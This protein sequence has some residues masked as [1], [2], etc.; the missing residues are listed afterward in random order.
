MDRSTYPDRV[1]V[2]ATDLQRDASAREEHIT[3]RHRD[4]TTPGIVTGCVVSNGSTAG[5][6][7]VTA[8]RAYTSG[9][10]WLDVPA[11][12]TGG[13]AAADSTVANPASQAPNNLVCAVYTEV[14]GNPGAHET[15]GTVKNREAT[16]S[17]RLAVFT[18]AQYDALPATDTDL[19]KDAVDR[20]VVLARCWADGNGVN[21]AAIVNRVADAVV[22]SAGAL[23]T[24]TGVNIVSFTTDTTT[25]DTWDSTTNGQLRF[26]PGAPPTLEYQAPNDGAFG[27]AVGLAADGSVSLASFGGSPSMSV[28][29]ERAFLPVGG[30]VLTDSFSVTKMYENDGVERFSGDD[31]RHRSALGLAAAK[32]GN[33]HGSR[34]EDF[35]SGFGR[36]LQGLLLGDNLD[37][38]TGALIPRLVADRA[39]QT[40]TLLFHSSLAGAAANTVVVGRVYKNNSNSLLFTQNA[41]WDGTNWNKDVAGRA[42]RWSLNASGS[43]THL[44]YDPAGSWADPDWV[45]VSIVNDASNSVYDIGGD[46]T[47][48]ANALIP[49]IRT[50]F[51]QT[52]GARTL[53]WESYGSIA[54]ANTFARLYR[55]NGSDAVELTW[56]AKWVTTAGGRWDADDPASNSTIIELSASAIVS[57]FKTAAV[58]WTS[59]TRDM[60]NLTLNN[61]TTG[62]VTGAPVIPPVAPAGPTAN[63]LYQNNII[64]ASGYVTVA[65]GVPSYVGTP[66]NLAT[67]TAVGDDIRC[68]FGTPMADVNYA[69]LA[70]YEGASIRW[71]NITAKT[72]TY[73]AIS[74]F[75]AAGKLAFPASGNFNFIVVGLQ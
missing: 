31:D 32:S 35:L 53:I 10:H 44:F 74:F 51:S 3:R 59:W 64:K 58:S 56:N 20:T 39:A 12:A 30:G 17:A 40:Y 37:S 43:A 1:E 23:T 11:S 6:L 19:S 21:M 34:L 25:T 67:V 5:R 73:V 36:G 26:T 7:A 13:E 9:G 27:A 15:D 63:G 38:A 22:Y 65:G 4:I 57:Q 62:L 2:Q 49:R 42:A 33:P 71:M 45:T 24:I 48:A 29:V 28:D 16:R 61:T 52:A 68:T 18:Q 41:Y 75:E 70:T 60:F 8:G 69:A 54:W 14:E 46:L 47:S 55:V 66:F 50:I 72:T